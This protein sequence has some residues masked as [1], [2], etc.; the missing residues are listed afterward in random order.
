MPICENCGAHVTSQYVRV[1]FPSDVTDPPA[2]H[3]C[4]N[5]TRE[6]G[7]FREYYYQR[8]SP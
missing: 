5:M 7:E 4:P 6:G 2:C 3:H 8:D 1:I